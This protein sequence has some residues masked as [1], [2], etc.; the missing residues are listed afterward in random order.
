[1]N[2]FSRDVENIYNFYID[3]Y[4]KRNRVISTLLL[5]SSDKRKTGYRIIDKQFDPFIGYSSQVWFLD[6]LNIKSTKKAIE[7]ISILVFSRNVI[8]QY[9][10]FLEW[11]KSKLKYMEY[12]L[13]VLYKLSNCK[14]LLSSKINIEYPSDQQ[15]IEVQQLINECV[16][17]ANTMNGCY[18]MVMRILSKIE[19]IIALKKERVKESVLGVLMLSGIIREDS[20]YHIMKTYK[21]LNDTVIFRNMLLRGLERG[22]SQTQAMKWIAGA[23]S[24]NIIYTESLTRIFYDIESYDVSNLVDHVFYN[25][26]LYYMERNGRK[27]KIYRMY[28]P[29]YHVEE[30]HH[31]KFE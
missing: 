3:N 16:K 21:V 28:G 15:I 26:D 6:L 11:K 8:E 31:I 9:H 5:L 14:E 29:T 27:N 30:Y 12:N 7:A 20:R 2:Q 1:M 25:Q 18:S 4:T 24:K 10:Q 17:V 23:I 22:Q 19:D 13:G